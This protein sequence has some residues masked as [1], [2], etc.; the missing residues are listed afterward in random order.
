MVTQIVVDI[1][2]K[3]AKVNIAYNKV[4]TSAKVN[5]VLFKGSIS[6]ATAQP[7]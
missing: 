2:E 1:A 4:T 6:L 7:V 3:T 5:T